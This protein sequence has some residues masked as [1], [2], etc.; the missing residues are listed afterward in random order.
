M[1]ARPHL[2]ADLVPAAADRAADAPAVRAHGVTLTAAEL[3]RRVDGLAATLVVSGVRRGDRVGVLLRKSA[4]SVVAVHGVL[5]AGAV[6]VPLDPLAPPAYVAR[7]VADCGV[8]VLITDD[9]GLRTVEAG[10]TADA[11]VRL[12][13]GPAT[14]AA[15]RPTVPWADTLAAGPHRRPRILADDPAYVIYTSGSTGSPK[16]IVHSH[17]SGLR[18]AELAAETYGLRPDDRLANIA[19]L[20]FDQS[21]F[22]LFAGPLA[23]ACTVVVP[24]AHVRMPASLTALV[25]QER[26]TVWYSVPSLLTSVLARGALEQRDL[27]SLRWV[28][29]GGEVLPAPALRELMHRWPTARFSNV[30]GPAEINQCTFHHVDAPPAD[31]APVPIGRAWPDTELLVVDDRGEPVDPGT[32]GTLLVRTA[33]AMLGYWGRP[34]PFVHRPGPG[35]L[36]QRWYPTGDLVEERPDGELVFL[37]RADNQVKV[38]GYRVELEGVEAAIAGL[39][40]VEEAVVAVTPGPPDEAVLVAAVVPAPGVVLDVDALRRGLA[41]LLPAHAVPVRFEELGP[42]ARTSGG[43][44]DRRLVRAALGRDPQ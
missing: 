20:H 36:S 37:G 13:V 17:R 25:A 32:P 39:P 28:L 23:G 35:G 41:A 33:T 21:T 4:E 26:A 3:A 19:P 7:L 29:F 10:L 43:K 40:G 24:E 11:P 18:Y 38:R 9:A 1:T 44:I 15:G 30:Y 22:E 16:G 12:L 8:E 42:F 2:L 34:D 27:S 31:D 5:A 14:G 6:S